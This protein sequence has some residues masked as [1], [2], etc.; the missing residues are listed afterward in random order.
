MGSKMEFR[1]FYPVKEGDA[2]KVNCYHISYDN[3]KRITGIAYQCG[4][5]PHKDSYFQ[6]ASIK[7]RYKNQYEQRSF[8]N[9]C[10]IPC[11]NEDGVYSILIQKNN[12]NIPLK[13][14]YL[15]QFDQPMSDKSQICYTRYLTNSY[16]Q[17]I[18]KKFYTIQHDSLFLF[19]KYELFYFNRLALRYDEYGNTISEEYLDMDGNVVYQRSYVCDSFGN[20]IVAS[21]FSGL[22]YLKNEYDKYGNL[23]RELFYAYHDGEPAIFDDFDAPAIL[24]S[25]QVY[26]YNFAGN[27]K[28]IVYYYSLSDTTLEINKYDKLSNLL[29]SV[30]YKYI[31]GKF[32]PTDGKSIK[33]YD[34]NNN[35]I[36]EQRT[37]R[38]TDNKLSTYSD[39]TLYD[40]RC[41]LIYQS[42]FPQ[43]LYSYDSQNR[44]SKM[45]QYSDNVSSEYRYNY[46]T[47]YP[48][49]SMLLEFNLDPTNA[50]S[51][52]YYYYPQI[53]IADSHYWSV[54]LKNNMLVRSVLNSLNQ[55]TEQRFYDNKMHLIENDF[56]VAILRFKYE[57]SGLLSTIRMY[58]TKGQPATFKGQ[59]VSIIRYK[60]KLVSPLRNQ[61]H[62]QYI[63]IL[64]MYYDKSGKLTRYMIPVIEKSRVVEN[65][66]Y[67]ANSKLIRKIN[68]RLMTL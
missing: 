34:K 51:T 30:D 33:K 43:K 66:W 60:Y 20:R 56:G 21:R 59:N 13:A 7:I 54:N 27:C 64:N 10:H 16:G 48:S 47:H 15:N 1:A 2:A 50:N 41:N 9:V 38:N 18:R 52:K 61:P 62:S 45:K 6:V 29:K 37:Y 12:R 32:K 39:S 68:Q 58:N 4:G 25:I 22:N 17:I 31:K 28:S 35:L 26:Q 53:T 14:V 63:A 19:R 8:Y 5:K 24:K 36:I 44:I 11:K 57:R 49:D 23:Q 3:Q 55:M 65:V 40:E 42:D 67:D 46:I